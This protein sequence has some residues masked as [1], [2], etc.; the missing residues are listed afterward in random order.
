MEKR[1]LYLVIAAYTMPPF[2]FSFN[3]GSVLLFALLVLSAELHSAKLVFSGRIGQ[4]VYTR[5]SI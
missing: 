2:N 3:A 5:T 1:H 4:P